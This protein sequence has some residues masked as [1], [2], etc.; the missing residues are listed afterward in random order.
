MVRQLLDKLPALSKLHILTLA[1]EDEQLPVILAIPEA[2]TLGSM[3]VVNV[4]A[5][6]PDHD[7]DKPFKGPLSVVIVDKRLG[8]LALNA[9]QHVCFQGALNPVVCVALGL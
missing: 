8:T 2:S 7:T 5:W 3:S 9:P 1:L 6:S 4:K